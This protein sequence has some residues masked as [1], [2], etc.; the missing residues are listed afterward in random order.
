MKL[1]LLTVGGEKKSWPTPLLEEYERKINFMVNFSVEHLKKKNLPRQASQEKKRVES[2]A[3]IRF[4]KPSDYVILCDER[5]RSMNSLQ[6]AERLQGAIEQGR[7]RV[8]IVIGGA[9]GI[10]DELKALAQDLW[11]V[12]SLTLNHLVAQVVVIEQIY[13]ALTI[14]KG[15]RYH[16]E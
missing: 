6:F 9:Y 2:E 7:Q 10:S 14:Q 16:N 13:R 8:I 11:S 5:G 4:L 15:I 3:I 12:S 1:I